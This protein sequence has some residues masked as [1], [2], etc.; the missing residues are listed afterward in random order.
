MTLP[1]T[2]AKRARD[3]ILSDYKTWEPWYHNFKLSVPANHWVYVDPDGEAIFPE[4][5]APEEPVLEQPPAPEISAI[6]RPITRSTSASETDQQAAREAK[7]EEDLDR[8]YK[9]YEIYS[10]QSEQW[11]EFIDVEMELRGR[12]LATVAQ[13]KAVQLDAHLPV[14]KWLQTLIAS[15]APSLQTIQQPI[16]GDYRLLISEG[17]ADWP[18]GGPSNWLDEWEDLISRADRCDVPFDDWLFDISTVWRSVPALKIF[19][20]MVN[21][22]IIQQ[23]QGEYTTASVSAA[24][25]RY[26]EQTVQSQTIERAN[27]KPKSKKNRGRRGKP[28][29]KH[30]ARGSDSSERSAPPPMPRQPE[31]RVETRED[32]DQMP[33]SYC[34]GTSHSISRCLFAPDEE[35]WITPDFLHA[36]NQGMRMGRSVG[37]L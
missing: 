24:I 6:S 10:F 30:L 9:K 28:Q 36:F 23:K 11:E 33:C 19:F 13:H 4:P 5:V 16:R 20:D 31:E 26:W 35:D 15:T 22:K 29:R 3:V 12:I 37:Q 18:T 32:R 7:Y 21:I 25:Q 2:S 1:S 27:T 14:R 17:Y 34:G 8:F